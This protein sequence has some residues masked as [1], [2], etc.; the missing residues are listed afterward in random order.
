[1]AAAPPSGDFASVVQNQVLQFGLLGLVFICLVFRKFLVPE[2]VL[3]ATEERAEKDKAE[4][5]TRLSETREQLDRLQTVF[6]D[7][8]IPTL[9][10]ATEVN[11]R[12]TDELQ[13]ARYARKERPERN[14][15]PDDAR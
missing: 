3:K 13:R 10:R 7:Q 9:T 15:E 12:Y 8:M 11:A 2:W 5:Q 4:L 6:E 1:M 14:D